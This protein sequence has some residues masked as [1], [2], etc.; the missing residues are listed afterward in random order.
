[1]PGQPERVGVDKALEA[2]GAAHSH[3]LELAQH[4][5]GA[6][7]A[8]ADRLDA[9][10][11][12]RPGPAVAAVLLVRETQLEAGHVPDGDVEDRLHVGDD[13]VELCELGVIASQLVEIVRILEASAEAGKHVAHAFDQLHH[14]GQRIEDRQQDVDQRHAGSIA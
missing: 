13:A 11:V 9:K 10:P 7:E 4:A 14:G 3:A 6:L 1:M 5:A 2:P 8:A 12:A